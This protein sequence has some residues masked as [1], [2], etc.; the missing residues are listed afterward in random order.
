[1][2]CPDRLVKRVIGG[3]KSLGVV[4]DGFRV[5]FPLGQV[6][7][8]GMVTSSLAVESVPGTGRMRQRARTSRPR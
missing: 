4:C 6:L 8:A 3:V 7:R 5:I 1:M 2:Y